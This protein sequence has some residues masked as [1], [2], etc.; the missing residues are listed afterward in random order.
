MG[1]IAIQLPEID[2]RPPVSYPRTILHVCV[3]CCYGS[4]YRVRRGGGGASYLQ[5]SLLCCMFGA[6]E[7]NQMLP[8][9]VTGTR[10]Q[11]SSKNACS[12][13]T[14]FRDFCLSVCLFSSN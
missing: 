12:T 9:I 3:L 6:T 5:Y 10:I 1:S 2:P 14:C 11:V 7:Y 8:Q 13:V 4:V